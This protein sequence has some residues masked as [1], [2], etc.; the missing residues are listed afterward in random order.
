MPCRTC[1]KQITANEAAFGVCPHCGNWLDSA[2]V[3]PATFKAKQPVIVRSKSKSPKSKSRA[4]KSLWIVCGTIVTSALLLTIAGVTLWGALS[5]PN[6][7]V[8]DNSALEIVAVPELPD[9]VERKPSP[10]TEAPVNASKPA[11]FASPPPPSTSNSSIA[12]LLRQ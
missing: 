3:A 7:V 5:K 8:G 10:I 11:Q 1:K 12:D 4:N 9:E 6:S 2:Q